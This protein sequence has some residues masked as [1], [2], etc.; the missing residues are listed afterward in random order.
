MQMFDRW[1]SGLSLNDGM[2]H[3]LGRPGC[4]HLL[5][6]VYSMLSLVLMDMR[7]LERVW[8]TNNKMLSQHVST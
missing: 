6:A 3:C 2:N 7:S 1:L 8:A 5:S 4:H